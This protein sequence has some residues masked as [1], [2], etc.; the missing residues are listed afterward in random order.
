MTTARLAVDSVAASERQGIA[1]L[2]LASAGGALAKLD[3][4]FS[5]LA[6]LRNAKVEALD[7][8]LLASAVY[9]LD[10]MVARESTTDS[11]TRDFD[12]TSPVSDPSRWN[13]NRAPLIA[14]LDFLSGDHWTVNFT[15][16]SSTV[17]R[18]RA[19]RR[20]RALLPAPPRG[21]LACLFSGGLDSLVGVIDIL[22]SDQSNVMLIGHHDG[23][24]KGPLS[25]QTSLLG[26]LT[27]QYPR[28]IH[29][30]LVRVGHSQKAEDITLRC[31]SILFI[32]LGIYGASALG[33]GIPLAIPENGTIALNVPLTP[34]RRGSCS[35]RTTHP[36]FLGNLCRFL[37]AVGLMNPITT[38]LDSKTKG[39]V[40]EQCRNLELLKKLVPYSVSCAKRGHKSTW[41]RKSVKSCGRC[42][43]CIYRRAALHKLGWDSERY[44]IDI[45]RGEVDIDGP[46]EAADDLR[47]CLS[48]LRRAPTIAQIQTLLLCNGSLEISASPAY[49]DT[50]HR[51][52]NEIRT[53]LSDKAT[54]KVRRLAGL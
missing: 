53:L 2:S 7:F 32:A 16:H 25:D 51:A 27:A 28:R 8:L 29:Q 20:R 15:R 14:A 19:R 12:V 18:P 49:A 52:M 40:V 24:M 9:G 23:Q 5:Q 31:R 26:G 4:E 54:A 6:P 22:E 21:D 37:N 42:M 41:V 10:K 35:T 50:V 34:S 39:E 44:G 38:P 1:Q 43:P 46:G 47:A 36:A 13:D 3:V 48:F 11:W 45:C 30:V 33:P 17:L